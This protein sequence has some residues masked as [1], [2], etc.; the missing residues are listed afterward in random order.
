MT[1]EASIYGTAVVLGCLAPILYSDRGIVEQAGI[2]PA[3]THISGDTCFLPQLCP[4][5]RIPSQTLE[6]N[7]TLTLS[8]IHLHP[9]AIYANGSEINIGGTTQFAN[10]FAVEGGEENSRLAEQYGISYMYGRSS[11]NRVPYDPLYLCFHSEKRLYG[12]DRFGTNSN[13]TTI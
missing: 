1:Y 2:K 11:T 4:N 10:N 8:S 9:G 7:L 13:P 3:N 6:A 5:E 12:S